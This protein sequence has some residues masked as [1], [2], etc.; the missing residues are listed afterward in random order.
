L[1][2]NPFCVLRKFH[3]RHSKAL[4]RQLMA[5]SDIRY[6][7]GSAAEG[8]DDA[9]VVRDDPLPAASPATVIFVQTNLS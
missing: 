9:L 7:G 6:Q 4:I 8:A 2:F 3:F 5:V 1:F